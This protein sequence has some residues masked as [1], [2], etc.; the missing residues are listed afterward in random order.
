MQ[1]LDTICFKKLSLVLFLALYFA[2]FA[3]R[4]YKG[5][6]IDAK[7]GE[8][9]PY[10]NIG[11]VDR[12]VGTVSD[13][14]G[15]FHLPLDISLLGQGE[16]IQ[17]SCLGYET[18]RIPVSKIELQYNEYPKLVMNPVE[19]SLDEVVVT[20]T[21]LVP[22]KEYIGYQNN[23]SPS[24]GYWKDNVALGGELATKIRTSKGPRQLN[25]L[26]FEVWSNPSD[27]ILIRINVY[28]SDGPLGRP[29]TNLN[30]SGKDILKTL[31]K[32]RGFKDVDL[33]P[34]TIYVTDD[35]YVSLELLKV[36]G[37]SE[38]DLVLA[39]SDSDY[40][41]YRKYTSQDKWQKL[42]DINMAYYL[43]TSPYVSQEKAKRYEV[44]VEKA[45]RKLRML[46]GFAIHN[47]SMLADV[48]VKNQR[49]RE[50]T[51]TDDSGRYVIHA[52]KRDVILFSKEGYKNMIL[53]V[54]DQQFANALMRPQE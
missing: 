4:D 1:I 53:E 5:Q 25:S 36:Y 44:K 3:Q 32:G 48:T 12:G 10:V 14:N 29:L 20:N 16:A 30:K 37:D 49:T 18:I 46:S 26:E 7:T 35:F 24:L 15:I 11:I 28:D 42:S 6:T 41:S 39:A 13:E 17:I 47:G 31:T 33:E 50:T 9:V 8:P 23:G 45:R 2:G 22:I 40:G 34:Y 19:I 21:T 38:I 54:S 52:E 43:E 27:S 51:K